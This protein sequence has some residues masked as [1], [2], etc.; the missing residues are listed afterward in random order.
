[1]TDYC[2]SKSAAVGFNEALRLE[3]KRSGKNICCTTICPIFFDTGMFE[4]VSN[5]WIFPILKKEY[6]A[7]RTFTAILQEEGEV[8]IPQ[9]IGFLAH[10]AKAFLPTSV[11]DYV[12]YAFTGFTTMNNWRGRGDK[13]AIYQAGAALRKKQIEQKAS[14]HQAKKPDGK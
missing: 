4:G 9:H 7:W 6:V 8:P 11:G 12:N 14:A 1:M 13:N 3:M 5:T 2:A 10:W